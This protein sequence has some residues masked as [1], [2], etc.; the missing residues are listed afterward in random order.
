M[1][2]VMTITLASGISPASQ[3]RFPPKTATPTKVAARFRFQIQ[4]IG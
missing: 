4:R 3:P 2:A 1:I